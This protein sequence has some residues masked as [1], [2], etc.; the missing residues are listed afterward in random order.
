MLRSS[1]QIFILC[2]SVSIKIDIYNQ[3]NYLNSEGK[4]I[5]CLANSLFFIHVVSF[6]RK[7]V[8]FIRSIFFE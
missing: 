4:N 3:S 7:H 1:F 5:H 8:F 2:N 6:L